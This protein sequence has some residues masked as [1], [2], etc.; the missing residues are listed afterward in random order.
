VM[1][2]VLNQ[3]PL[4]ALK[5]KLTILKRSSVSNENAIFTKRKAIV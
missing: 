3:D 5:G 4:A 2:R 1:T